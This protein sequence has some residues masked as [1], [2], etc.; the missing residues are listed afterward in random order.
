ME[1][2]PYIPLLTTGVNGQ[3]HTPVI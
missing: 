2:G 1:E 3:L